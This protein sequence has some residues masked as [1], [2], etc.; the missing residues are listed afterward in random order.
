MNESKKRAPDASVGVKEKR[1]SSREAS[2]SLFLLLT[3]DSYEVEELTPEQVSRYL[4]GTRTN[5]GVL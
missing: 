3:L 5:L 2:G 4:S 1:N